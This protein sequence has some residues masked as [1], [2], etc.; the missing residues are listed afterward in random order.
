MSLQKVT[1]SN[2]P[3]WAQRNEYPHTAVLALFHIY[4]LLFSK[5]KMNKLIT[6]AM[7]YMIINM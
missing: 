6:Y 7:Y 4:P 1:I 3:D 2:A 5:L